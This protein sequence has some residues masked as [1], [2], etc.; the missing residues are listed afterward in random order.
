MSSVD[1]DRATWDDLIQLG[2]TDFV[3]KNNVG[4]LLRV[5]AAY[6]RPTTPHSRKHSITTAR[7]TYIPSKPGVH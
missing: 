2:T 7:T 3:S 6:V 4:G 5:V 1:D